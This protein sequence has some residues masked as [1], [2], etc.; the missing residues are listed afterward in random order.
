MTAH[1]WAHYQSLFRRAM[2]EVEHGVYIPT[3]QI[4]GST[5]LIVLLL[6]YYF[7]YATYLLLRHKFRI[8]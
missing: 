7:I 3:V 5:Y 8:R 2:K 1:D 6:L 4:Y